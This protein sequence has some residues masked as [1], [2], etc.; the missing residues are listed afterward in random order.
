MTLF[1]PC[2][3]QGPGLLIGLKLGLLLGC[4][5]MGWSAQLPQE[6]HI[7]A[8]N[9]FLGGSGTDYGHK[10]LADREGN[11]YLG[12]QSNETW[13]LPVRAF[14]PG[15]WD[16]FMAKL[17]S[18][19]NL[20]WNTFLGAEDWRAD[21]CQGLA[22]DDQGNVYAAGYSQDNWGA[23][24]QTY[25]G[26]SEDGFVAKLDSQGNLVWNTFLGGGG[27]EEIRGIALDGQ[28]NIF[29]EG[30]SDITWGSPVRSY[31]GGQDV[32]VA[33]LDSAGGLLWNTFLGSFQ[34]DV[35]GNDLA[36]DVSGN[37]YTNGS[38]L[39]FWGTPVRG[40][41][42]GRDAFV[43]KVSSTGSL[44]WNT[45]L[46]GLGDEEVR[47]QALDSQGNIYVTGWSAD[48]GIPLA[49]FSGGAS[50]AFAAR[51]NSDGTLVWHTFFG[52]SGQDIGDGIALNSQGDIFISG[53]SAAA[54]GSP[55]R[56]FS[57][58]LSDAF[59]VKLDNAGTM[60]WNTF[61]GSSGGIGPDDD[62]GNT[63]A[64][65]PVG[66]IYVG[67]DSDAAWGSPIRAFTTNTHDVFA[68]KLGDVLL[69]TPTPLVIQPELLKIR[70]AL[71]QPGSS[72]P[73]LASL[74]LKQAEQVRLEAYDLAGRRV[75]V[76]ADEVLPAGISQIAWDGGNLGSGIYI[77][78]AK[79]RDRQGHGKVVLVR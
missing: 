60:L 46:G 72:Q 73:I 45:F 63:L 9:T 15:N 78:W 32:F 57:G 33:K 68:A 59:A 40:F 49:P 23:P 50:D 55:W 5:Q 71:L 43:A 75:S 11:V 65:D 26:G 21:A 79:T 48:W 35:P 34:E 4:W 18:R 25:H 47:N 54:W 37:L 42:G 70:H 51:L 39:A 31:S 76:I 61:L 10:I 66:N 19:G 58:G 13:G 7:L 64:L 16:A 77:L 56:A 44:V 52:C 20:L 27:N 14:N 22:V 53:W 12:G 69:T 62:Y 36:L 67:G 1:L 3:I 2:R 28:G 29:V 74:S 17:D 6:E 30:L 24:L 41:S 8:W 38:S